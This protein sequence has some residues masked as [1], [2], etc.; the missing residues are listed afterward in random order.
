MSIPA[1]I[2]DQL[3]G[4]NSHAR[5]G[6]G[7]MSTVRKWLDRRNARQPKVPT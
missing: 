4:L 5:T 7:F 2:I 1:H 6:G 3:D